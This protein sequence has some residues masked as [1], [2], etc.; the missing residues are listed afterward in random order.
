MSKRGFS[1]IELLVV[2]GILGVLVAVG[3]FMYFEA[4][5]QAKRT[6]HFYNIKLIK[7]ALEIYYLKK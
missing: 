4:V 6:V 7:E 5:R 2:I 1:L 3:I